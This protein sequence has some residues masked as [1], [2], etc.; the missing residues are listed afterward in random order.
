MYWVRVGMMILTFTVVVLAMR[1]LQQTKPEVSPLAKM[2]LG[3]GEGQKFILCPTRVTSL[4]TSTGLRVQEREMKWTRATAAGE[5]EL[6]PIAVEK[7]FGRNCSVIGKKSETRQGFETVL[8]LGL[9]NGENKVLA[10]ASS[11]VYLWEGLQ[12]VSESLDQALRELPDL[13]T[14]TSPGHP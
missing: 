8:K 7:W 5:E 4:E 11:G 9:V 10:R 12:F 3:T 13:P 2:I 14:R 6:D 1:N